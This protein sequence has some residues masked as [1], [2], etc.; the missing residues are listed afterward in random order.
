MIL[1]KHTRPSGG[2]AAGGPVGGGVGLA[3]VSKADRSSR[4]GP[5]CGSVQCPTRIGIYGHFSL[6]FGITLAFS[7]FPLNSSPFFPPP[8]YFSLPA[9][10]HPVSPVVGSIQEARRKNSKRGTHTQ[11]ARPLLVLE[12][13]QLR[14]THDVGEMWK[15]RSV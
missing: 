14:T 6:S 5:V 7:H 2:P 1:H 4:Q 12:Q 10:R 11:R 8:L 15:S 13:R 9:P 3:S